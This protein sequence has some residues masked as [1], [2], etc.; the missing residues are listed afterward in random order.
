M[1]YLL[2]GKICIGGAPGGD[3]AFLAEELAG[4]INKIAGRYLEERSMLD[5][6]EILALCA[7]VMLSFNRALSYL[8]Y[9]G[10]TRR[11]IAAL[12]EE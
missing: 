6:L 11:G 10:V 8:R 5:F 12:F 9:E 3:Q 1:L 2:V 4:F 7:N